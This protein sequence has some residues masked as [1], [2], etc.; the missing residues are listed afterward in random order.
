MS[1]RAPD[2]A[3][4][5][6]VERA[7]EEACG[8]TLS[9]AL[10][11]TLGD[12]FLRAARELRLPP[13]AFL[14]EIRG[15]EHRAVAAMVEA[16]AVGETSFFRHPEQLAAVRELQLAGVPR[17]RPL[18]IW[19]AGCATGEEPYTLAM[20]LVDAGRAGL[21]DR[22]L[23]TD[24][25]SRALAVAGEARYGEWSLRH[26]D[27]ELRRRHFES[28]PPQV[29]VRDPIRE[30][31]EFRRHNLVRDPAPG[32]AFD[33]I[34]CRNVLIY[35]RDETVARV[36]SELSER[37]RPGGVLL[38]GVSESLLRFG[39]SLTCEEADRV[40]YYRRTS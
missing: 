40:F 34:L 8:L 29:R 12:A 15:G 32:S 31:V 5:A 27:P 22:I 39:T 13:E 1:A 19:S 16:A 11:R 23:A 30:M 9:P 17:D 37:L 28:H 38:V 2:P 18:S 7:L 20:E 36:I 14:A 33:L 3:A 26:L 6:E 25:S 24:V 21:G 10:H 4:L 35:F